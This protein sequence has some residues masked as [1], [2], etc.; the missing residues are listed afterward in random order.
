VA[1]TGSLFAG[2]CFDTAAE[3]T[4][5]YFSVQP[6]TQSGTTTWYIS[7]FVYD[8]A[9]ASYRHKTFQVATN[10][11][12]T[13]KTNVAV[14]PPQFPLCDPTLND[15]AFNPVLFDLIYEKGLLLFAV[16]LG[17]GL[18]ISIIRKL[19]TK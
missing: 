2:R 16:G 11:L 13:A 19:R 6:L 18:I 7:Q 15:F 10:G 17:I 9:T 3:A 1:M 12:W 4:S 5:A 14:V 8:T